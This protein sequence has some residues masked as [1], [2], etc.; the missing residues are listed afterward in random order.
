MSK[1]R[2]AETTVE[3]PKLSLRAAFVPDSF[4]DEAGTVDVVFTTGSRVLRGFWDQYWE[5]LSLEKSAV[6]LDRLNNGASVLNT[7]RSDDLSAVIGV[8]ESGSASVNGKEGRATIRFSNREDV[9]PYKRDVKEGIIRN[10]SVGFMIHKFELI[11][12][13]DGEIPVY[14]AVDWEPHELSF[15]PIPADAGAQTRSE[16]TQTNP[17]IFIN[18]NLGETTMTI[19]KAT[20]TPD[21]TEEQKEQEEQQ[22]EQEAKRKLEA[23][24]KEGAAA[25]KERA[26]QIRIAVSAAKLEEGFAQELINSEITVDVARAKIIDKLA[27]ADLSKP[28]TRSQHIE[29][30]ADERDKQIEG[31]SHSIL[32]RTGKGAEIEKGLKIKLEPGEFRGMSLVEMA[33]F[34]AERA[35]VNTKGMDKMTLVG[36]AF[37]VRSGMQG[38]SDFALALE[39]TLH[40]S[41]LAAWTITPD[42]WSAWCARGQVSDFRA[43]NRYELGSFGVLDTVNEHGEFK[44]KQ[45]SDAEKQSISAGTKGNLVSITRHAIINDDMQIFS[46]L[47]F[48]LGR[49][50]KLTIESGVY[51]KLALN[52]GAGPALSDGNPIFFNRETTSGVNNISTSAAISVANLDLD[53]V[54]MARF[55]DKDKNEYLEIKPEILLVSSELEGTAR[56]LN[57][58]QYDPDSS[59]KI[60]IPNKIRGLFRLVVGT[61]RISGNRRYLFA[62]PNVAPVMEVV[63]LDGNETPYL[64][65][66]DGWNIDG[67]ELK[68]RSDFGI[69]GVGYR[70]GLTNAGG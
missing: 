8:V 45:M 32:Q 29:T 58:S 65:S 59:S 37:T 18:R 10:I 50:A 17:C 43:H 30:L 26:K 21:Q 33:R 70:G 20:D 12:G 13:G 64:E 42:T 3:L 68:V 22:K 57:D 55:K 11:E 60:Q 24:K 35:G 25:E 48:M 14:R 2:N 69:G 9:A 41:L 40:K 34:F 38:T 31:I 51:T 66:K 39:N 46:R 53:R 52:S 67:T 54:A 5:E 63:F 15:V 1:K 47:P 28:N 56:V 44:S 36:R 49:A 27:E 16:K 62:D 6:R 19:K 23:A 4:N 61:P 7:H